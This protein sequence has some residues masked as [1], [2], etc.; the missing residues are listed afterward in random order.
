M[1]IEEQLADSQKW[2]KYYRK[3]RDTAEAEVDRLEAINADLLA[4]LECAQVSALKL[5][6]M[7]FICS[8][9]KGRMNDI[10]GEVDFMRANVTDA[11]A[12]AEGES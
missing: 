5:A 2:V 11:I 7:A 4:A 12:K 1:T 3:D 8:A 6:H 10:R 9:Y